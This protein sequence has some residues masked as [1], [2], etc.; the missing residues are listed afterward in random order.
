MAEIKVRAEKLVSYISYLKV[1]DDLNEVLVTISGDIA[2]KGFAEEYDIFIDAFSD[3]LTS[4]K[5]VCCPGNHDFNFSRVTN[6]ARD[7]LL[8]RKRELDDDSISLVISGQN[9]YFEFESVVNNLEL[10]GESKLSKLYKY[11][12]VGV[13][14]LNTAWSS[15]IKEEAGSL[16]FP[17]DKFLHD[18]D[19]DLSISILHHPLGWL[20]VEN[21]KDVRNYLRSNYDVVI[22]GHEHLHD[23]FKVETDSSSSLFIESIPFYDAYCAEN[24]IVSFYI[25]DDKDIV[26]EKSV[27]DGDRYRISESIRK[28]DVVKESTLRS[29]GFEIRLGF[30]DK[31]NDIGTTFIHPYK[32][33]LS[34]DDVFVYPNVRDVSEKKEI[35]KRKS[36]STI[37]SEAYQ[38]VIISGDECSG[39]S[40]LLKKF[41][42]DYISQGSIPILIDGGNFCKANKFKYEYLDSIIKEQYLDKDLAD[43][44]S[45][46]A[47]KVLM[48]DDFD[49]IRGGPKALNELLNKVSSF[50]D[51]ILVT[52]SDTFEMAESESGDSQIFSDDY[53]RFELL[54]LGFR[55]RYELVNKW[56]SK[57]DTCSECNRTL[58]IENDKATKTI[59]SMIGKNFVPSTPL[60]LLTMLQS[61]ESGA[62]SEMNT[63][64]YGHYYQ[65]LIT[66]SLGASSVKKENLDEIFNY[67]KELSFH[68]FDKGVREESG[69]DLWDFN[70]TFCS[71]YGLKIDAGPRLELLVRSK[72]LAVNDSGKF[73]SFKY[74]Y[75]Y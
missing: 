8:E 9:D 11:E 26:V 27:W 44:T 29:N 24:G 41:Y 55:L 37:V 15:K 25:N 59:N 17:V 63:S 74:P 73:Y 57:K 71:E 47:N 16:F 14:A 39:K 18:S 75:I 19:F 21:Q 23:S 38:R 28:S 22:T 65:Y 43:L 10:V 1:K 34:I 51:V 50:F 13:Q 46:S 2:N 45:S 42:H 53:K 31:L 56:N 58:M 6:N 64:S 5:I 66:S 4:N 3:L 48:I 67:I 49:Q 35:I 72:I 33:E 12:N 62:S 32:D 20:E 70:Q 69:D 36:S 61:M 52:V 68:F 60:F 30:L 54:K 40:L 7:I